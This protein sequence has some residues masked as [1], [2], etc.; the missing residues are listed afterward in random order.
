MLNSAA[1]L[2]N[3]ATNKLS[4]GDTQG[5]WISFNQA[6]LIVDQ[7]QHLVEGDSEGED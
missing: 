5:A 4:G 3:D 2:L 1:S 6:N 7:T